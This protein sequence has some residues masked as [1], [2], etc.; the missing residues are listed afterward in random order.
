MRQLSTQEIWD[1]VDSRR[2]WAYLTTIGSD[3]YPHCV[4]LGYFRLG[5][6]L[7]CGVRA[8]TQKTRN[9]QNNP[10]VSLLLES[11]RGSSDLTGV[12]FQGDAAVI[13]DPEEIL[14][15]KRQRT[16]GAGEKPERPASG[17][18]YIRVIP[19]RIISWHR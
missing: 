17:I 12:L 3:G 14:E 6:V 18:A 2:S 4:A 1:F 11:G 15:I 8:Q 5:E 10:K 19:S 7:Y 9:V 13:D 16:T